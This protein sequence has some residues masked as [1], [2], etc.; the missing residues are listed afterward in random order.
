MRTYHGM[1][2]V[3]APLRARD[4]TDWYPTPQALCDWAVAELLPA[5]F[6]P[7]S[8]LDPGAGTGPWGRAARKRWGDEPVIMGV[9]LRD[10]PNPDPDVYDHWL[11]ADYLG[12]FLREDGAGNGWDLVLGNPPYSLAE[13]FIRSGLYDVDT[14]GGHILFLLRLGFLASQARGKGLW[15]QHPPTTVYVCSRRPSF[16][17]DARTDATEYG[18]Y[19]WSMARRGQPTT[20]CWWDWDRADT[21]GQPALLEVG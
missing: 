20:L 18:I 5:D 9:E 3:D 1:I 21:S 12:T 15:A 8:V 4:K 13:K 11:I 17:G 2:T 16:T 14:P 7:R 6:T 10:Q 19:H